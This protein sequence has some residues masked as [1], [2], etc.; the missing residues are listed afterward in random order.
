[1]RPR[2]RV[3]CGEAWAGLSLTAAGGAAPSVAAAGASFL[4]HSRLSQIEPKIRIILPPPR[5]TKVEHEVASATG[6]G[7][8]HQRNEDAVSIFTLGVPSEDWNGV[9]LA[10]ADGRGWSGRGGVASAVAVEALEDGLT[11]WVDHLEFTSHAWQEPVAQALAS[12]FDQANAKV[13]ALLEGPEPAQG[14]ALTAAALLGDWLCVAHAGDSRVYRLSK[15]ELEQLTADHGRVRLGLS[16]GAERSRTPAPGRAVDRSVRALGLAA[17]VTPAIRFLR[18]NAGDVVLVCS[19]GLSRHVDGEDL[20]GLMG[21]R[22]PIEEVAKGLVAA[23]A[24]RG[25]E[26]DVSACLARV[27]RLPATPLPEPVERADASQ[28]AEVVTLPRYPARP[29]SQ[30]GARRVGAL[31]GALVLVGGLAGGFRLWWS[32]RSPVTQVVLADT[33]RVSQSGSDTPAA[34]PIA[35]PLRVDSAPADSTPPPAVAPAQEPPPGEIVPGDSLEIIQRQILELRERRRKDSVAAEKQARDAQRL[36]DS[37]VAAQETEDAEQRMRDSLTMVARRADEARQRR[38]AQALAEQRER[39]RREAEVRAAREAA[40]R[41]GEER[42]TAGR[43]AAAGWMNSVVSNVNAGNVGA[44]VLRAGPPGFAAFV[45][46]N[47][48]KLSDAR[49]VAS[50]VTEQSAEATAEWTAKWR[51]QFGASTS[52]RMTATATLVPDGETWRLRSW[53]ITEGA[54]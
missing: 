48:P 47:E 26:D 17:H 35:A 28:V 16:R 46:K 53:T 8:A 36:R 1:V 11:G 23:A 38:E 10:V 32:S 41:A 27:G 21:V 22:R 40:A 31:L 15:H 42:V 12:A 44:P 5:T 29:S 2:A 54:P 3:S 24:E 13:R 25:A 6:A 50:D 52:R 14:M 33:V 9:V 30:W 19:D 7:L 43:V 4:E 39:E 34:E 45:E 37:L 18:L 20:A 49:L 51:T